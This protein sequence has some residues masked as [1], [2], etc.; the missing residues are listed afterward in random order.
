MKNVKMTDRLDIACVAAL[1]ALLA[2]ELCDLCGV[3]FDQHPTGGHKWIDDATK[4]P[5][6]S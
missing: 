5:V 6:L 2:P 4:E 1:R 3:R